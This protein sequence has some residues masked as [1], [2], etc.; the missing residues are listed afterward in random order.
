MRCFRSIYPSA[1]WPTSIAVSGH[2]IFQAVS[3][4]ACFMIMA[5]SVDGRRWQP[6]CHTSISELTEN[7]VPIGKNLPSAKCW[8]HGDG[9]IFTYMYTA[10][11]QGTGHARSLGVKS[12]V[13]YHRQDGLYK[14]A[15]S[16]LLRY[17]EPAEHN[18]LITRNQRV[19][20][21]HHTT[22]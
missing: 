7:G 19:D 6:D 10:L 16:H 17:L 13:L 8:C 18:S 9:T 22:V 5:G 15:R 2:L 12:R 21:K 11:E 4:C 1:E 20:R 3:G 14:L